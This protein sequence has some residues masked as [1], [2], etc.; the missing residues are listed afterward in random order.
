M[1]LSAKALVVTL[2]SS[3]L[4]RAALCADRLAT[5]SAFELMTEQVDHL[6]T[7][8][9]VLVGGDLTSHAIENLPRHDLRFRCLI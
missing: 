2:L 3:C 5:V 1:I 7:S 9:A 8:L 4:G 6:H